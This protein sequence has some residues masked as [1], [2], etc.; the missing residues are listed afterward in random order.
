MAQVKANHLQFGNETDAPVASRAL[1]LAYAQA[2]ARSVC[3]LLSLPFAG[4]TP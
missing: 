2:R 4:V 3:E 1:A